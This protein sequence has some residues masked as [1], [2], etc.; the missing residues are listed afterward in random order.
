M[1]ETL[2]MDRVSL[3]LDVVNREKSVYPRL[4]RA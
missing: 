4:L 2:E 3:A 1:G